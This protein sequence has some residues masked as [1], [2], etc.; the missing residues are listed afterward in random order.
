[1]LYNEWKHARLKRAFTVPRRLSIHNRILYIITQRFLKPRATEYSATRDS[2]YVTRVSASRDVKP[3][4]TT[5]QGLVG[6]CTTPL[7]TSR[8]L[9]FNYKRSCTRYG[10][11]VQNEHAVAL[12]SRR[13]YM[14]IVRVFDRPRAITPYMMASSC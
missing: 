13:G 14:V 10:F 4:L 9:D 5:T 2:A 11:C 8:Q 7:L 12:V 1:M 3:G 6:S